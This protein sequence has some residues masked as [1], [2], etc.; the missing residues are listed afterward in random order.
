LSNDFTSSVAN[1]HNDVSI[2]QVE[3]YNAENIDIKV[4]VANGHNTVEVV[5]IDDIGDST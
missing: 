1:G 2:K 5:C 4:V 3:Q